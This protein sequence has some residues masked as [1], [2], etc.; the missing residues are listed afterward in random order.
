MTV[1]PQG[2]EFSRRRLL[3]FGAAAGFLLGTGTPRRV[4]RPH[5]PA[6]PQH[7]DPGAQPLP[8]QPGQQAQPVRRRRHRAARRAPGPDRHRPRNSSPIL[9]LADSFEMTSPT[10]WTV[11]LREGVQLLRRHAGA[12]RGRRHGPED[13]PAGPGLLRRPGSSRS[14]PPWSRSMTG[15]F[16]L[17]YQEAHPDPRL[18]HEHDPDQPRRPRTSPRSCRKA[19]APART[20]SPSSTAAPAPTA[21]SATRTT[22]AP[23]PRWTTSRS[24]SCPE[25]SSRVIALR[26][27]EV[28]VIDSI[29][30][31]SREQLAG[32]PGV[33][34]ERGVQ[35]P[36]EPALLQLPQTGRPPAGRRPRSA[37]P[38]A[39]RSTARPWSRT[40]WWTRSARPRASSRPA[41]TGFAKT[42][43]YTYD[44]A[45]AK[46][47]LTS[48]GVTDLSLKIIWETGEF[49]ADTSVMEAVVEM[50]R[51]VGVTAQ[52]QQFEPGG[53]ILGLA[54]GQ[55]RR[56]GPA[57]QRLQQPHRPGHHHDAGHVRR[58]RGEG[59][60][61][62]HLPGLRESRTSRPRSRPRPPRW[63]P[64]AGEQL[65]ARR[66]R[67]PSG[68]PG[69][70]PGP[71][72]PK[73]VLAHRKR[74]ARPG[75]G[76]HQLLPPC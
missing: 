73:S 8:G 40:C 66:T 47:T 55:G 38:S 20:S 13:V 15:R 37:R 69:R 54:P 14:S 50:L 28:D 33:V 70:A 19:W 71:S 6:G 61:P 31:D 26:S 64:R 4:C 10:A 57:G 21:S 25:E 1:L 22:G 67:R 16:R 29:T 74:V 49:A 75:P 60:D 53:N 42:G 46:A 44:P 32:L 65:L 23:R 58:H 52:L 17:E 43:T 63:I 3:Q 59:K 9:V 30:P 76:A 34:L 51:H 12:D 62:R 72:F 5:R 41:S 68:T 18:P 35:P 56:L 11:R 48:L 27:G 39:T 7:P 36:A 45:K 2:S 24:G